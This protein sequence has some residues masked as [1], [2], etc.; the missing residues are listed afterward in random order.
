MDLQQG[1]AIL[2]ILLLVDLQLALELVHPQ[3]S[4][5]IGWILRS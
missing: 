2:A 1:Q 4:F 3:P 5:G